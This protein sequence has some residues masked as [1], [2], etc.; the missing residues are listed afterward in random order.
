MKSKYDLDKLMRN[1]TFGCTLL[2]CLLV[3]VFGAAM[4]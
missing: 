1:D 4:F 2:A 3:G